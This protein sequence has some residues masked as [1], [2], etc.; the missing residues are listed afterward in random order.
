MS[1]L[2]QKWWVFSVTTRSRSDVGGWVSEWGDLNTDLTDVTLVSDDTFRRGHLVCNLRLR[3]SCIVLY[4]WEPDKLLLRSLV[5]PKSAFFLSAARQLPRMS[6]CITPMI[7]KHQL[8]NQ[9]HFCSDIRDINSGNNYNCETLAFLETFLFFVPPG[10]C[11]LYLLYMIFLWTNNLIVNND[12]LFRLSKSHSDTY[13]FCNNC[14][15]T[16]YHGSKTFWAIDDHRISLKGIVQRV[17]TN[18]DNKNA[19]F[20]HFHDKNAVFSHF[21]LKNHY[22]KINM[23]KKQV[24]A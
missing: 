17:F 16:L 23:G 2:S 6:V 13:N 8:C 7:A 15:F 12:R 1:S 22:F 4:Q 14:H 21:C 20:K 3:T 10:F 11:P 5:L 18:F 19:V 24:F 9:L